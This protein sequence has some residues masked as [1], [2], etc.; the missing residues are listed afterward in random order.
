M[1]I[2]L[3]KTQGPNQGQG[4][5]MS[6]VLMVVCAVSLMAIERF[7]AGQVGEF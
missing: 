4:L 1:S 6:T 5:A 2:G 3:T 7:R